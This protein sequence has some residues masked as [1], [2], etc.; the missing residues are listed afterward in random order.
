MSDYRAYLKAVGRKPLPK[1]LRTV[2]QPGDKEIVYCR[3]AGEYV[4]I[5]HGEREAA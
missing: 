2:R 1:N 3:K 4:A 5:I